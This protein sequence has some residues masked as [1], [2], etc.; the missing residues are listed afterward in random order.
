MRYARVHQSLACTSV[1]AAALAVACSSESGGARPA[2]VV[3]LLLP[4]TGN[5]SATAANF[6]RSVLYAAERINRGGGVHGFHL[7]VVEKDSHSDIARSKESALELVA[8]GASVVLGPESADI[9]PE[10]IPLLVANHVTLMSPLVG[11]A[12]DPNIDC[13]HPWFRLAPSAQVLGEALGKL[14]VAQNI[15]QVAILYSSTSY[16]QALRDALRNR[17][18]SLGGTVAV[19]LQ[20]DPT[21]Q[22]YSDTIMQTVATGVG[23]IVVAS[24]PQSA[25][26]LVN[27]FGA[28]VAKRPQWFLSPLLKTDLFVQNVAPDA[29]EGALG[30]AP[31]IYDTSPD[32]SD[33]FSNRWAGDEPLEGAKFYYDAM[34]L[35]GLALENAQIG[36][37]GKA[38]SA[39]LEQAIVKVAAPPGVAVTWSE[40]E[41]GLQRT[42]AGETIYYSG[43]TG[44]MLL[45]ACGVR[46]LGVTTTW[47][48]TGGSIVTM[49]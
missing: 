22:S 36:V 43:L 10:L 42:A 32:F 45:D 49:P 31:K 30:V 39:S 38:D 35:I 12:A 48:V 21:A 15:A 8:A 33:A 29:I 6:E 44:P 13:T 25:A 14:I 2:V 3:G 19:E 24:P 9:A 23:S 26:L 1:L 11:A 5:G 46:K 4:Y 18:T 7:R 41:T 40:V 27:E 28:I 47:S 37:D 20:L 16:D 17:F 34:G